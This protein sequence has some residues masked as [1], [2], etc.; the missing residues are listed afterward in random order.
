MLHYY[1]KSYHLTYLP[2]NFSYTIHSHDLCLGI[3]SNFFD[4][5]W[6]FLWT[7][8]LKSSTYWLLHRVYCFHMT[9]E[10]GVE[11]MFFFMWKLHFKHHA[12]MQSLMVFLL[13]CLHI[14]T[15]LV[16]EVILLNQLRLESEVKI[17]KY[18]HFRSL[19]ASVV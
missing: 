12:R 8:L 1:M 4:V 16:Y 6:L 9:I 17:K 13:V 5:N 11:S 3:F 14:R 19:K 10:D 7:F 15:L 18:T 2:S